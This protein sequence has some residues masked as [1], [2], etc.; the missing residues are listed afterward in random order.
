MWSK[1]L[2]VASEELTENSHFLELGG[3]SLSFID[4]LKHIK[5]SFLIDMNLEEVVQNN[6]FGEMLHYLSTKKVAHV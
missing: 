1:V 5:T 4:L 3:D 2:G 6:E